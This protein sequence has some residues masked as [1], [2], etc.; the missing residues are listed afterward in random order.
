[1]KSGQMFKALDS[2]IKEGRIVYSTQISVTALVKCKT[3]PY[4]HNTLLL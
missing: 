1:M 4:L 2:K 3:L